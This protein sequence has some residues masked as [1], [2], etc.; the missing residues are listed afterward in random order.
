MKTTNTSIKKRIRIRNQISVPLKI[1][2]RIIQRNLM[3][4]WMREVRDERILD[5][6]KEE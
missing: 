6:K 1:R 3:G 2:N 4:P 5:L